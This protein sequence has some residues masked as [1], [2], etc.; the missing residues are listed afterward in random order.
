VAGVV[1]ARREP[2]GRVLAGWFLVDLR[3]FGL[4][5]AW[6]Y[7]AATE[8]ELTQRLK[9]G[10]YVAA[11]YAE[12][13]RLLL[14]AEQWAQQWEFA[15]PQEWDVLRNLIEPPRPGEVLPLELFGDEDGRPLL[16][17]ELADLARHL[18]AEGN[19]APEKAG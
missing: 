15:L 5:E 18:G 14:A 19:G 1:I 7:L 2:G 8:A 4:R 3:G 12:A 10:A 9:R 16:S 6:G 11:D 17:G 13:R